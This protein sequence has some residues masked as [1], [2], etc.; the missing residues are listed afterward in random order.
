MVETLQKQRIKRN[1]CIYLEKGSKCINNYSAN[2][3]HQ[4]IDEKLIF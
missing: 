1:Y 3:Q 2:N 4:D